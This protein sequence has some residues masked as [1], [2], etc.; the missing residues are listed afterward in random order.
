MS[1]AL[2]VNGRF[3]G[4][5]TSFRWPLSDFFNRL[6]RVTVTNLDYINAVGLNISHL[7]NLALQPASFG[8]NSES[9]NG[10][11]GMFDPKHFSPLHVFIPNSFVQMV[12]AKYR[13]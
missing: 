2:D 1:L 13:R 8:L 9:W 10:G 3:Y 4:L 5:Y 7:I 12:C 6:Q 11:G